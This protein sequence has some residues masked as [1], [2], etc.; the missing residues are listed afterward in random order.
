MTNFNIENIANQLNIENLNVSKD[1]A[2]EIIRRFN[3]KVSELI[4]LGNTV[5]TGI[6]LVKP[7]KKRT[8]EKDEIVETIISIQCKG[9]LTEVSSTNVKNTENRINLSNT[10]NKNP[11]TYK[12]KSLIN[13][14]EAPCG[15]AFR[16]WLCK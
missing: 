11:S 8:T 7:L 10:S 6:H 12:E 16:R 14:V 5:D 4:Q 13:D 9:N 15:I 1:I 3:C 2:I